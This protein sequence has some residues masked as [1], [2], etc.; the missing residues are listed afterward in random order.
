MIPLSLSVR[1]E[2]YQI[3]FQTLVGNFSLTIHL[4]MIDRVEMQLGSL[5]L[6]QFFPKVAGESWIMV[7]DNRVGHDMDFED[8]IHENLS[9]HGCG[10][11]VLEGTKV[12]IFGKANDDNHDERF[13]ARFW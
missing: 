9:H 11:Q 2:T 6:E 8:I 12:S 7:G 10:E 4:G 13:I 3:C 5:E 1:C